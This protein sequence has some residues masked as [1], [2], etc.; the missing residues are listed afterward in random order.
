MPIC[1]CALLRLSGTDHR[2]EYTW[3][4]KRCDNILPRARPT[5]TGKVAIHPEKAAFP[6]VVRS[7]GYYDKLEAHLFEP[8]YTIQRIWDR[9]GIVHSVGL[10]IFLHF[11]LEGRR[12]QFMRV[13]GVSGETIQMSLGVS[14]SQDSGDETS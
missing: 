4:T 11:A 1:K 9:Q 2:L 10:V 14:P 3:R 5:P 13:G 6:F 7:G 12:N 8:L